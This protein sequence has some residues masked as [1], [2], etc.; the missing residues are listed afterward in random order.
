[1][2]LITYN[3][4]LTGDCNSTSS[5]VF[6][7]SFTTSSPPLSITWIDP[8]SGVSFSSQTLTENPYVVTGL[9]GGTYTFTLTDFDEAPAS[10][11]T[12]FFI[13][14]SNTVSISAVTNTACGNPN[15]S[16]LVY[17]PV[18]YGSNT[19]SLYNYSG[20]VVTLRIDPNLNS[21]ITSTT[22]NNVYSSFSNLFPGLYYVRSQDLGGC[23]ATS[24][25][26]LV[27][28]SA[29]MDFGFY[30]V[31]SPSCFLGKGQIHLTGVTGISPYTYEWS[32]NV[33]SSYNITTGST[34]I[35]LTG[36]NNGSYTL[37]ITD[38]GG[39]IK[40]KTATVG[41]A[42]QLGLI[43]YEVVSPSCFN[44]TGAITF[45]LYDSIHIFG[46]AS[47]IIDDSK[48][49]PALFTKRSISFPSIEFLNF[50]IPLES[51]TSN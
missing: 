15:G 44:S 32:S 43:N 38:A 19:L 45:N 30:V 8:V 33:D 26:V 4:N 3:Y 28:S 12:G 34:N 23:V 40:T 50:K 47:I 5:G 10:T 22:S 35:S 21:P 20:Q 48:L 51:V 31:N 14:T 13:T 17:T 6:S 11:S 49:D 46:S 41:T 18:V 37:T 7:L 36:L 2:G 27:K 24:Q 1:M 9:S 29:N 16:I 39:C 25:T 42:S